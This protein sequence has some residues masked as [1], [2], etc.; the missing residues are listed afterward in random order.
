MI[1]REEPRKTRKTR[2]TGKTRK[3]KKGLPCD[4][5]FLKEEAKRILD[6]VMERSEADETEATLYEDV[7]ALTR[8]AGN[9][10][11]QNVEERTA[12]LTVRAIVGKR[13]GQAMTNQLDEASIGR[14]VA[15][16]AELARFAPEDEELPPRLGPQTYRTVQ[17]YHETTSTQVFGPGQRALAVAEVVEAAR[18]AGLS[19]AG[20]FSNGR[21]SY[22]VANSNGLF[23]YHRGSEA[24]F[25]V[26][27]TAEDSSGWAEQRSNNV[28]QLY[29]YEGGRIAIEK[30][31]A[32]AHPKEIPSGVYPVVLEPPAVA[33]LVEWLML[34]YNALAVDEGRSFL[35]GK[36]GTR[37]AGED[38]DLYSDPYHP[39]HQGVPFDG[40]GAPRKRLTL[41]EAG[42][43]RDLAF[44]RVTARKH[45][46]EPTGHASGGR[47]AEGA[48]PSYPVLEGGTVPM[49]E[50]I[51]STERGILV[52]RFWYENLVDPMEMIVTGMTRDGLF[53]IEDGEVRYGLKNFRFNQSVPDLLNHVEMMSTPVLAGNMVAPAMKVT[54]FHFSS[55]TAF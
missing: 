23:A 26:T 30:A 44:D 29:P 53:W 32:S 9:A 28:A 7:S 42:V 54:A 55:S 11:H 31:L 14:V 36:V 13:I 46:V 16:A 10:I 38:I 37:I 12:T 5:W 27:A 41:I 47:S 45:G 34:S 52:T 20:A 3:D 51:R 49:E 25:S 21:A 48:W 39:L 8:F 19:V 6:Q 22:A 15:D 35:S 2:K 1:G 33:S 17:A 43:V 18:G 4:A 24:V 40:E 50:M